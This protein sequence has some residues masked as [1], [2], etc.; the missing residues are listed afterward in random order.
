VNE[1]GTQCFLRPGAGGLDCGT[2]GKVGSYQGIVLVSIG[3]ED[4]IKAGE[5]ARER[6]KFIENREGY[7]PTG[8]KGLWGLPSVNK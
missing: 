6:I 4:W 5:T 3:V 8:M 2:G 7:S 1:S